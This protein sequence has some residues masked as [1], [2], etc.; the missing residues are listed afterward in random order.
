[1]MHVKAKI[2]WLHQLQA[3]MDAF[4]L[5][6]DMSLRQLQEETKTANMD[7]RL[8]SIQVGVRTV[9]MQ[10]Q[11]CREA[12]RAVRLQSKTSNQNGDY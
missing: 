10:G 6:A 1:M 9:G 8:V 12:V 3:Q 7:Q 4:K 5:L 11:H 2:L